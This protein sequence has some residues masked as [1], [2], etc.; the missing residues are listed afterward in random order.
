MVKKVIIVFVV[1]ILS[2]AIFAPKRE[3]YYMLEDRL[4]K[5]GII[6][7]NEEIEDGFISLT[8]NHPTI[9][10]KGILVADIDK[11]KLW[12]VFFYSRIA[13]GNITVNSSFSK[14]VPSP[15]NK[16]QIAYS[17]AN[18][19]N[20]SL[21]ITG[22]FENLNGNLSINDKKLHI[23]VTD[24]KLIQQFKSQLKK[25]ENGWYYETSL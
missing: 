19:K 1:T 6:I 18:P 22:D 23:D 10:F 14:F 12:T 13:L 17:L 8:L 25:G 21:L 24:K 16:V 2:L 20:L 11:I 9:Y 7:H 15:I 3:L 5:N 4:K